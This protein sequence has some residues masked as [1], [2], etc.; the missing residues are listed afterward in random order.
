M[1][2]RQLHRHHAQTLDD[3]LVDACNFLVVTD[4]VDRPKWG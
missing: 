3:G 4:S 1:A 2:C